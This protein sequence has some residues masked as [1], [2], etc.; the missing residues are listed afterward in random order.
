MDPS[1]DEL[2]GATDLF[3]GL[4]RDELLTAFENLAARSGTPF[5]SATLD[6]RLEEA[7]EDYYLVSVAIDDEAVLVP[8]PAALPVLPE[9]GEDLPH[10][11][12]VPDR[13]IEERTVAR[14]VEERLRGEAARVI[15]AED[16]TRADAL[17]DICYEVEAW[18]GIEMDTVREA[19]DDIR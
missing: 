10:M 9:R 19:L 16:A 7:I 13:T 4:T 5:D 6:A 2:A 3:G 8:G 11:M 12:D 1:S 15:D 17:L 18:A 14:T